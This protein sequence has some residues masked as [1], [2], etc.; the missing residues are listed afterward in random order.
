MS[1]YTKGPWRVDP[2]FTC[3][4]Q[5][6]N[7]RFEIASTSDSVLHEGR[8]PSNAA[9]G[10]NALLIAAAPELLEALRGLVSI[11]KDHIAD[12]EDWYEYQHAV[13]AIAKAVQS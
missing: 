10:A 12:A 2:S 6:G 13:A 4:V 1:R 5:S 11:A 3:D 7:G 9:Q 8:K